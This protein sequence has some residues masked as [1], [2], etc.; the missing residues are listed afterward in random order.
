MAIRPA[1]RGEQAIAESTPGQPAIGQR[2]SGGEAVLRPCRRDAPAKRDSWALLFIPSWAPASRGRTIWLFYG[3]MAKIARPNLL[4]LPPLAPAHGLPMA[5]GS[6]GVRRRARRQPMSGPGTCFT[7]SCP[8][9]PRERLYR[10]AGARLGLPAGNIRRGGFGSR[11]SPQGSLSTCQLVA[12]LEIGGY[13]QDGLATAATPYNCFDCSGSGYNAAML[14]KRLTLCPNILLGAT[15]NPS[16]GCP[17]YIDSP[18]ASDVSAPKLES[19]LALQGS[20]S[21]RSPA[22]ADRQPYGSGLMSAA[23]R[24]WFQPRQLTDPLAKKAPDR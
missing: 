4:G 19:G 24:P 11:P 21:W 7:V 16:P 3:H 17:L 15:L 23:K 1:K 14:A 2:A 20:S 9:D 18:S 22:A 10:F 12:G 5:L 8:Y 13:D 6:T